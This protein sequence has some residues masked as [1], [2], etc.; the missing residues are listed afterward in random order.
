M[1]LI[2]PSSWQALRRIPVTSLTLALALLVAALTLLGDYLPTL[3][4]FT[5]VPLIQQGNY[6]Y[7]TTLEATLQQGQWWRL[8]SPALIHFG[9]LHLVFNALW[10]WEGGRRL[11]R[12]F[13]SGSVLPLLLM[14][15]LV[16]NLAQY[17]AGSF[18]FGGLSG[19]VYAYLA[20]LWLWDRLRPAQASGLPPALFGF[21]LVW[22]ALGFTEMT[23]TLGFGT[24]AN[25]AHVAGL[26]TGL[27]WA[28]WWHWR[29]PARR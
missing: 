11:E 22:L 13:G 15:A 19:V 6:L 8:L 4:W 18:L 21:M 14:S 17:Y 5:I 12:M 9:A 1:S 3:A 7:G 20:A 25:A 23:A 16:A 2:S 29:V 10:I 24:M 26:L 27:V 28:L